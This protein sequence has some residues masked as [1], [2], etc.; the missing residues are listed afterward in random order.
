MQEDGAFGE[1][2]REVMLKEVQIV[3][4]KVGESIF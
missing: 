3:D 1:D 2:G 4:M